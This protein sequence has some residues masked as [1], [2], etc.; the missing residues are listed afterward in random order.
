[1]DFATDY[2]R[3]GVIEAGYDGTDEPTYKKRPTAD[4]SPQKTPTGEQRWAAR[5]DAIQRLLTEGHDPLLGT[6]E[7]GKAGGLKKMQEVFGQAAFITGVAPAL[8]ELFTGSMLELGSDSE[9]VNLIRRLNSPSIMDGLP[10]ENPLHSVGFRS[11]EA[12]FSKAMSPVPQT[13]PEL[14]WQED[15]LR[16]SES[17]QQDDQPFRD[18]SGQEALELFMSRLSRTKVRVV[19]IEVA[20]LRSYLT[21]SFTGD[22]IYP[23]T[24]YAYSNPDHPQ[25]PAEA[26][27][28]AAE[29]DAAFAKE[30][31][32]IRWLATDYAVGHP[33]VGFI[34]NAGLQKIAVPA[35]GYEIPMKSLRSALSELVKTWGD[36]PLPPKYLEM[37]D[38]Y[39]S[40]ADMFQV[41]A[42]VLAEQ[43]RSGNFPSSVRVVRVYGPVETVNDVTPITGEVTGEAVAR[44]ASTLAGK[45]HDDEWKQVPSNA[46]PNRVKVGNLDVTAAQFLRLMAEAI[47]SSSLDTKLQAKA[48][49]A[50]WGKDASYFRS[51]RSTRDLGVAWTYKPALVD[52]AY[53]H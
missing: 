38:H 26:R 30:D 23:P 9:A 36:G 43:V 27:R 16:L 19:H 11:W 28:S 48:T 34:S 3:R 2:I 42:D 31:E 39:L 45:L 15:V 53:V 5:S 18:S 1:M 12:S 4:M 8:P 37:D 6:V 13:S 33:K 10:E 40:L 25:L 20:N 50:F 47:A 24:R 21:K 29:V 35:F 51:G 22:D 49:S 44:A 41:M 46:I 7:P 32:V 17:S 52:A 14:F